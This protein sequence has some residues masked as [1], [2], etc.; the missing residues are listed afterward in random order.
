MVD[1]KKE[2]T[3]EAT[4][5]EITQDTNPEEETAPVAPAPEET[6]NEQEAGP[7]KQESKTSFI[8]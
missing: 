7:E 2:T 3:P 1:E 8:I 4:P 6:K 5:E